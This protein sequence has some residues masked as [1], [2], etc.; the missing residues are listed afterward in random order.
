MKRGAP[1]NDIFEAA[2][3]AGRQLVKT[4]KMAPETL[5]SISRPLVTLEVF[6]KNINQL[7]QQTLDELKKK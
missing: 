3:E 7:Y 5:S 2:K 4:G 1:V 6:V